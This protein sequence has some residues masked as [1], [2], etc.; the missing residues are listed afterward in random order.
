MLQKLAA[1]RV[2][3]PWSLGPPRQRSH[4]NKDI[5]TTARAW[6]MIPSMFFLGPAKFKIVCKMMHGADAR[7]TKNEFDPRPPVV[8]ARHIQTRAHTL[9]TYAWLSDSC[10][11]RK[12]CQP[13]PQ[14]A[15]NAATA[16]A[17]QK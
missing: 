8:Y 10:L 4:E 6:Q 3:P 14:A 5:S 11:T 7:S 17:T 1:S 16:A 12:S 2:K 15:Q 13:M 9:P